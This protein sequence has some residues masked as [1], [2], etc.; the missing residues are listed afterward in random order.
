M[1]NKNFLKAKSILQKNEPFSWK[2]YLISRCTEKVTGEE[3]RFGRN[4]GSA[5]EGSR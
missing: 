4:I 3:K 2:K 1:K 5:K